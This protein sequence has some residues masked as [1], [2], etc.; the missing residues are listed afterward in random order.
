MQKFH[1]QITQLALD[2]TL[3]ISSQDRFDRLLEVLRNILHCDAAALLAYRNQQFV[4]LAIDGLY[5]EVMGRRFKLD[6]HPRLEAIARAGDVVRFPADSDIADPYDGLIPNKGDKL[7]VH[8][9]VGLPL[10]AHGNLIGALTIDGFD[11][12]QFD[13][14]SDR[15]LRTISALASASLHTSLLMKQLESQAVNAHEPNTAPTKEINTAQE[16]IGQSGAMMDLRMQIQAVANTD[17]SVLVTG[18]T[19]VGKELVAAAIHSQSNRANQTLVY[20]NCAALPESVAESELFG[21]VKGAFTGAISHRKGKFE[22]ADNG[23][24]FLDE[25]G[26]LPLGLQSK[27]LRVLQ[28]GDLQRVGDDSVL[29]VNTRIVA[30]T[31]RDLHQDVVNGQFRADL[32]HRLSV[33]PIHVPPLREREGDATLL[34]GFFIEKCKHKL[35]LK[36]LS[37]SP[38]ALQVVRHYSW[39]G[40]VRQLEHAIHRGAVLAKTEAKHSN[41]IILQPHHFELTQTDVS[42]IH[43]AANDSPQ[44]HSLTSV[45]NKNVESGLKQATEDF[46]TQMITQALNNNQQNWAATARE[47]QIDSGNL[48][49][50]AK[51]LGLKS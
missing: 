42:V 26:E 6:E 51:R 24:L 3:G 44:F 46:Q 19:G 28:Y 32:Y 45:E 5:D 35:N 40:N 12:H 50:L 16:M 48:H 43:N 25:V 39:P 14:F 1:T 9:C 29:K 41:Q 34:S 27:L 23:T 17:L 31:N 15:D 7:H 38:T 49:R 2:L 47:L 11:A 21:H 36:H 22:L 33:F 37:I 20:L 10:I 8:A 30:A 18:E 13:Q 4:P